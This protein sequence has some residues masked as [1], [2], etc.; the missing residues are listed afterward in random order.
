MLQ[1]SSLFFF[2]FSNFPLFLVGYKV[3]AD[4]RSMFGVNQRV[5]EEEIARKKEEYLNNAEIK[6][7]CKQCEME[8]ASF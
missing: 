5:L 8:K 1:S 7:I 4:S 3:K 6:Q 2:F